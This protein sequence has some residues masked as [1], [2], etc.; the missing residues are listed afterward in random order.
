[1]SRPKRNVVAPTRF[2]NLASSLEIPALT[3]ADEMGTPAPPSL[4]ATS[5]RHDHAPHDALEEGEL[6][7]ASNDEGGLNSDEEASLDEEDIPP[8]DYRYDDA[9]ELEEEDSDGFTG[10]QITA[11]EPQNRCS[12]P[13]TIQGSA[14]AASG[15][16]D[17]ELPSPLERASQIRT[18][19]TP[20]ILRS[21]KRCSSDSLSRYCTRWAQFFI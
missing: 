2:G 3:P 10:E 17:R 7:P 6:P 15:H 8:A 21:S 4:P 5:P 13:F 9:V 20:R 14:I 12:S 1:M 16:P 19:R 18:G 11:T